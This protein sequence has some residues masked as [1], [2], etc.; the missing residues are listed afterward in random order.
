MPQGKRIKW[1]SD[2]THLQLTGLNSKFRAPDLCQHPCH[3]LAKAASPS[4]QTTTRGSEHTMHTFGLTTKIATKL[5]NTTQK[6]ALDYKLLR[7][8]SIAEFI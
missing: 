2:I 7:T 6:S 5:I 1:P 4:L 3:H 8:F